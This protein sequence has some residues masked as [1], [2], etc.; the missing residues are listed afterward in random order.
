MTIRHAH[1]KR[2]ERKKGMENREQ[3]IKDQGGGKKQDIL[4]TE[5]FPGGAESHIHQRVRNYIDRTIGRPSE[6]W[7]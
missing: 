6:W 2:R 4:E 3:R 5:E 7:D 1:I